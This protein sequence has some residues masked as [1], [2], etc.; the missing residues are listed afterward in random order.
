MRWCRSVPHIPLS[1]Q[2]LFHKRTVRRNLEPQKY[3]TVRSN[4]RY[5][6]C[7]GF[8]KFILLSKY[9]SCHQQL[10]HVIDPHSH[11]QGRLVLKPKAD[12]NSFTL[13]LFLCI[14]LVLNWTNK[15]QRLHGC[16][17]HMRDQL[18]NQMSNWQLL[19]ICTTC[20]RCVVYPMH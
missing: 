11:N 16:D 10:H 20:L 19:V 7:K 5:L 1:F 3:C 17:V 12:T 13:L 18:S 6:E 9:L 8:Q 14:L 15:Y 4:E 2:F